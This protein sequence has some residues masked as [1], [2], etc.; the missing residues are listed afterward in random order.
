MKRQNCTS[1]R[2]QMLERKPKLSAVEI[3][4]AKRKYEGDSSPKVKCVQ[5][6]KDQIIS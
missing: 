4:R 1:E 3:H 6:P 2:E 5:S